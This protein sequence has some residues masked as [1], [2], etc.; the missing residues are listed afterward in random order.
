M[1]VKPL[2]VGWRRERVSTCHGKAHRSGAS[3][4]TVS[5]ASGCA[6]PPQEAEHRQ[7]GQ[8]G[9]GRQHAQQLAKTA[10]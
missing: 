5:G 1:K 3:A 2:V 8:H 6:S 9:D 10:P 4:D 7:C